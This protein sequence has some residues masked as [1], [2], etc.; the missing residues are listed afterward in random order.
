MSEEK[1]ETLLQTPAFL[2]ERITS[3]G[4]TTPLGQWYDQIRDEWV[5]LIQGAAQ[6]R[7]ENCE[8]LVNLLPG[9]HIHLPAH[10]RHRVEWTDPDQETVWIALHYTPES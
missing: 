10:C 2:L 3:L 4:H 6:L 1:F 5:M 9:D 7:M 8:S